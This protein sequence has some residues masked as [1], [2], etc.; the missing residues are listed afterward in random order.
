MRWGGLEGNDRERWCISLMAKM[1]GGREWKHEMEQGEGAGK[2]D[3]LKEIIHRM[4][5]I[6]L[7]RQLNLKSSL[8]SFI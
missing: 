2:R 3:L 7:G 4:M 5:N 8:G 6:Y 1:I